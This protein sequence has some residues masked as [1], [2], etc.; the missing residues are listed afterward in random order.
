MFSKFKN[1]KSTALA[2][3]TLATLS[4]PSYAIIDLAALTT[5]M[6][7]FQTDGLAVAALIGTAFIAIAA[8]FVLF[9]WIRGAIFS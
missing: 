6:T 9:K 2:A 5:T 8:A 1:K 4:S 3:V 7:E